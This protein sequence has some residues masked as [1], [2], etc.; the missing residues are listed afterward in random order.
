MK[1]VILPL[2]LFLTS[3]AG[4]AQ[5]PD[6]SCLGF[7]AMNGGTTGGAGAEVVR[8][9]NYDEFVAAVTKKEKDLTPRYVEVTGKIEYPG[10]GSVQ[11]GSNTTIVGVGNTAFISQVEL[12]IKNASNVII[13]NIRF[14]AIGSTK[15][16]SADMISIATT[17]SAYC[18]NIWI[19]H[20]EFY[21]EKP[22]RNPSSS[23]KDKY[24]GMVDVKGQSEYITISW[25]YFHDHYKGCLFGYSEG[26]DRF[27]RKVT[28]HHNVFERI[29]SRLPSLRYG[30]AHIYNNYYI[31]TQDDQGWFGSGPN[32]RDTA[33]ARIE[34]NFFKGMNH[35][36]YS[37]DTPLPG[38]WCARAGY[39]NMWDTNSAAPTANYKENCFVLPEGYTELLHKADELVDVLK[40][41][42]TVGI[43]VVG[44]ESVPGAEGNSY[45]DGVDTNTGS[46]GKGNAGEEPG[47][48]GEEEAVV[49]GDYFLSPVDERG[50]F[51]F[52]AENVE[53]VS[54]LNTDGIITWTASETAEGSN[55]TFKPEA[56]GAGT[57]GKE[58]GPDYKTGYIEIAKAA[59]TGQNGGSLVF[60]LPS[61][62]V[63][64]L[65]L[66]RTGSFYLNSYISTDG[67]TWTKT[68]AGLSKA[69]SGIQEFDLTGIVS[70]YDPVY[71]KLT[72]T[73]SGGLRVHG[74]IIKSAGDKSPSSIDN[75]NEE[76]VLI[77]S[78]YY[79]L[80][81][82]IVDKPAKNNIYI[83]EDLF[84]DGSVER[85]KYFCH[86][87]P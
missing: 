21:N 87:R 74:A 1:N 63:M 61:C 25:C 79:D 83:Q 46:S 30:T 73:S 35:T 3:I 8:V 38:T 78:V 43:G 19:D 7:A 17:G 14:S 4:F 70:S 33:T 65:F 44:P 49:E 12:Y 55:S 45:S 41:G 34:A 28:F 42:T 27:D 67:E 53:K 57:D 22:I 5:T 20:C 56:K 31:G 64:K 39:D 2:I 24:D 23:L 36:I 58:G 72:N 62:S 86:S 10:G 82:L 48:G 18:R 80:S 68:S 77:K 60:K 69:P 66:S 37:M 15:G 6:F 50:Y 81:G 32:I 9:T 71:V 85:K 40:V 54:Q 29:N 51:W 52:N 11:V 59:S 26:K 84:D 75:F 13:Q 47:D 16:G 76:R